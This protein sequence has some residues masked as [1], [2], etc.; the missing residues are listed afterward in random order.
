[1]P[2]MP[3]LFRE[4]TKMGDDRSQRKKLDERDEQSVHIDG[5][6]PVDLNAD[7]N[8]NDVHVLKMW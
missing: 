1:M 3:E 4:L 5:I 2:S 8:N 6:L 7:L